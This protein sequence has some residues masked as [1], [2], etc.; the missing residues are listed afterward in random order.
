M[1]REIAPQPRLVHPVA[2]PMSTNH[3]SLAFL[4][5]LNFLYLLYF[6]PFAHS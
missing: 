1:G 5:L 4:Y 3:H 2:R 6:Q